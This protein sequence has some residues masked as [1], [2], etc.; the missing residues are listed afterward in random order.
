MTKL[1]TSIES[2]K[3]LLAARNMDGAAP[4]RAAPA[5]QKV[6]TTRG[7]KAWLVEDY[8]L[9]IVT[10]LFAFEGGTTQDSS[11][12]EGEVRLMTGLLN[13]GAGDLSSEVFRERLDDA[14]A[15]MR[16]RARSEAVY[17][18]MR[19]LADQK[20]PAFDLLQLAVEQPRFDQAPLDRVRAQMVT[21]IIADA[22]DP[23]VAAALAWKKT[24]YGDHPYSRQAKG[25]EQTLA[26]ITAPDLKALH[27]RLF[28]RANLTIAVAGAIDASTLKRDLDRI[29]AGLPAT[30]S[31]VPMSE[32]APRLGQEIH[33]RYDLPQT[34]LHLAYPGIDAKDPQFFAACLTNQ[35]LGGASKTSRLYKEVREKRG[36]TYS[37]RSYLV[38][39]SH[40]SM[41]SASTGTRPDRAAE[42]LSII[43]AEVRQMAEKGVSQGEL[44]AAKK[45]IIGGYAIDHL[46]SSSAIVNTLVKIQERDED[47]DFI[48]RRK[49]LIQAVTIE[50]VGSVAKRLLGA[51]PS[52]MVVG[53][54][55]EG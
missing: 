38:N 7:I 41:L 49:Q 36:L 14:D 26:T 22:K 44:E 15:E 13:E 25:T 29:F 32:T 53:Q 16:F 28:A 40:S 24:L 6:E 8:S 52:I 39:S 18:Y 43:R 27:K 42:T 19:V 55:I 37:I 1:N 5:I 33:I 4:R 9:P 20:D 50:D 12:K 10:I 46:N 34:K 31:L 21:G 45:K 23:N 54:P 17:G 35:I 3:Q 51:D 30:P 47:I 2:P 48:E 11:G